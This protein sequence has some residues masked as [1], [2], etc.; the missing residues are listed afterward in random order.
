MSA[1]NEKAA[2]SSLT[3]RVFSVLL[4]F[5]DTPELGITDIHRRTGLDKSVVHRI[6]RSA[7]AHG[8]LVQ[9]PR[10]RSYG[11]G[12]RAWEIGRGYRNADRVT[13]LAAPV[14]EELSKE[15]QVTSYLG[16]LDDLEVVYLALIDSPGPIRIMQEVGNRVPATKTALG[17]ALL[18]ELDDAELNRRLDG[19]MPA[20]EKERLL[21]TIA[22]AR[23]EGTAVNRGEFLA[24][25]GSVG[26]LVRSG[27]TSEPVAISAAF[28]LFDG[29]EG[30]WATL[31]PAV[32]EAAARIA[33]ELDGP[34][35]TR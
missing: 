15:H 8:F 18:A 20:R 27:A 33:G 25:V 17:R 1:K 28:L 2:E 32:R 35:T 9:N 30:M 10:N 26:A 5:L 6:V 24:G 16:R 31:P 22:R 7:V 21:T 11:V 3:D 23:A 4:A 19:R 14:L 12:L 13:A 34:P 29:N